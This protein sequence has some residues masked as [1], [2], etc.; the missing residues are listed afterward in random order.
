MSSYVEH[1]GD[2]DTFSRDFIGY[3][4]WIALE[5]LAPLF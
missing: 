5:M 3:K 4:V 2:S 1:S